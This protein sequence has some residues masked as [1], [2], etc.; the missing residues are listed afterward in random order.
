MCLRV[1]V[2]FVVCCVFDGIDSPLVFVSFLTMLQQ[3][4]KNESSR[5]WKL[6]LMLGI[7]VVLQERQKLCYET[8]GSS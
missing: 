4:T 8:F 2:F 7:L 3:G 5:N 1:S 6:V